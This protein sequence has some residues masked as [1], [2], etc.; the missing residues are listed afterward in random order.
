[1]THT[2][3]I[4]IG[5]FESKGVLV[6]GTGRIVA[7]ATRP[8]KMLVPRPGWAEHRAEEDWWGDFVHITRALLAESGIDPKDI[9]CVA[10]SAIGPCMLPVDATGAPL[11][12]GVLY[13]VDTRAAAEIDHLNASIGA[14]RIMA[15]CGNALT[16]QSVGPKILWLKNTHPDLYARTAKVLTSTSYITWKLTGTHV[17]DHYTAANFS[18]LYDVNALDWTDAL[19][20]DIL[21][22]EKL[23]RLMWSTDVAGHVTAEAA[24][25][26]GLATGTPVTCGTID[27]AAEAVSVGVQR[28][29]EMMMMY[30]STI[31]IIQVTSDPVRDQRL[32]YA[33]WLWPGM[34]ASMAGLAT[35]GTLTHW[36]RDQ[37]ARDARFGDLAAEAAASPKGAKGLLCLPYFSGERTPIHDPQAKG[38]FFGL[39]LTHT[40]GDMFRAVLEGIASGTAHVLETYRD[41]DAMPRRILAVGGGTKNA[42]WMQ[43]TSDIAGVGQ[44]LCEKTVGA[45]YGDAFL[46]ATAVGKALPDQIVEWNP[47]ARTVRPEAVPAYARQYPLFKRLYAQTRDIAHDLGTDRGK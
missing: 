9:A 36:F 5:T 31:F 3:G 43:A 24:A 6:D 13:G 39:D 46:A 19:A 18:P 45:S 32:W 47:V 30:G 35:S 26:T 16:S 41:L 37:F 22:L 27:A 21:P 1:M 42:V 28:P 17:I 34:H 15:T 7:T 38:A 29:G 40:R 4:D 33:P 25:E 44:I 23:P 14:E 12:N 8:H 20:P 2:L 11:M 10:A